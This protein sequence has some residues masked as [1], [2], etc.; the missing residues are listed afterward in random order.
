[1]I[2]L[3]RINKWFIIALMIALMPLSAAY[4]APDIMPLDEVKIGM[5]GIAKTVVLGTKIESFNVE[6]LG[7]MK[8]QSSAGDLIL[9]KASGSV[10]DR[11][12]GIVQGMS[13]SPVYIDGKVVGAIAYGWPL[14]DHT[15]TMVTPIENMLKLLNMPQST[16]SSPDA[17]EKAEMKAEA[18]AAPL[19]VSGLSEQALGMLSNHLKP[20]QLVPYAIGEAPQG[21][22][23]PPLEP[24]SSIGVQLV[25]GDVSVEAIGT[26]TYM[27]GNKVLAFGHPFLRRGSAEYFMTNAY[28]FT[29]LSGLDSGIKM[30]TT[31][32]LI[33]VINQ[34]RTSG[35]AGEVATYPAI[36]PLRATVYDKILIIL[37]T[38]AYKSSETN[39]WRRRLRLQQC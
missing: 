1:M 8:Q 20:Y 33:G 25:R 19:M 10:I 37:K 31:G 17:L 16:N 11:T 27:E 5:R 21:L 30:G 14:K 12:G 26:V 13:G 9:V 24:G 15:I 36:I 35:I 4:A 3:L 39:F 7:V 2:F 34:D 23:F 29:T 6:V 18:K 32:N 38:Q 22:E 28:I